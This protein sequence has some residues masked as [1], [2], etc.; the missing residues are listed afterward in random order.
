MLS[1]NRKYNLNGGALT[2]TLFVAVI[3]SIILSSIILGAYYYKVEYIFYKHENITLSNMSSATAMALAIDKQPYHEPYPEQLFSEGDDSVE[4][5]FQPWGA[6]DI[7]KVN[8]FSSITSQVKYF[9]RGFERADKAKTSVYLVDEGRPVS[10]S[11]KAK[12]NGDAYLP[13]AGIRSAYVGRIGYLNK[14]LI[15]GEKYDSEDEMPKVNAD[16]IRILGHFLNG[17]AE[18]LYPADLIVTD[19]DR[20]T[21]TFENDSLLFKKYGRLHLFDSIAGRVWIHASRRIIV[22]SS[23]YL[24]NVILTAPIIEIDSGFTG[25]LQ[26]IASDTILIASGVKLQYPSFVSVIN[27]EPPATILLESGSSVSGVVY[28]NGDEDWFN[29]R[30]LTIEDNALVEGMVYCHGMTEITGKIDGHLTTRKFLINTFSGVYENYIFNAQLD[31]NALNPKFAGSDLWFEKD[32]KVV[33][34]WLN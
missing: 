6:W 8:S 7:V 13:K 20:N 16:R 10:V 27:D 1:K 29:Q 15:Y 14:E 4:Y 3:S 24:K 26:A 23:A 18:S 34:Q 11:G 31:A 17:R 12:I 2:Y 32:E 25:S 22:D 9:S 30:I 28:M 33:L 21:M 19:N 5:T